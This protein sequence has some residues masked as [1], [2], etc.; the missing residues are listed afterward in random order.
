M[1]TPVAP[2]MPIG[3]SARTVFFIAS[4]NICSGAVGTKVVKGN[5][6][7]RISSGS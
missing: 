6:S 3:T 7:T 5:G 4:L 2:K 1:L